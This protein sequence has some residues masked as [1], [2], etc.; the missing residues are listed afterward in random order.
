MNSLEEENFFIANHW[1]VNP[2]ESSHLKYPL[3]LDGTWHI[4]DRQ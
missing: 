2:S 4:A 3:G 1:V